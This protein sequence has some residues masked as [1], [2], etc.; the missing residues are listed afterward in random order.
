MS[1]HYN[2]LCILHPQRICEYSVN[3]NINFFQ[4]SVHISNHIFRRSV[5]NS[6]KHDKIVVHQLHIISYKIVIFLYVGIYIN[7]DAMKLKQYLN[8]LNILKYSEWSIP[9]VG[10]YYDILC[11]RLYL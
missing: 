9:P 8:S 1:V 2:I 4:F 5:I 11:T 10:L 7:M 6:I 3:I